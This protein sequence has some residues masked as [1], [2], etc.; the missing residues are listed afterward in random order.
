MDDVLMLLL[1]LLS[2]LWLLVDMDETDELLE[3]DRDELLLLV[4]MEDELVDMLL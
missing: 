1:E 2:L 4:D 3:L